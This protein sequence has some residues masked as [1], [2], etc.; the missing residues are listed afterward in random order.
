MLTNKSYHNEKPME[1][2]IAVPQ[3]DTMVYHTLIY[4]IL[5]AIF[6]HIFCYIHSIFGLPSAFFL[7]MFHSLC[8]HVLHNII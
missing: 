3:T 2:G 1:D 6:M 7:E 5:I 4:T 8:K